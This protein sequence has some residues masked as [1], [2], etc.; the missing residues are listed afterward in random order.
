MGPAFDP[1]YNWLGIPAA[2]QPPNHYRLLGLAPLES[3]PTVIEHAADRVMIHLRTFAAGP[4]GVDSQRLLNE[5]ATARVCLLDAAKK[6]RYDADLQARLATAVEPLAANGGARL[7][8]A[9]ALPAEQTATPVS[10]LVDTPV[11]AFNRSAPNSFDAVSKSPRKPAAGRKP[12]EVSNPQAAAII[13]VVKIVMGGLGGLSMAILLVWVVWGVD[14]LGLFGKK[15]DPAVAKNTAQPK[16]K[17]DEQPELPVDPPSPTPRPVTPTPADPTDPAN[18]FQPVPD[19]TD[20]A[21]PP[22]T[23]SPATSPPSTKPKVKP[24]QKKKAPSN[25]APATPRR[26]TPRRATQR[27]RPG[28][29]SLRSSHPLQHQLQPPRP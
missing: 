19:P 11:I 5:V 17:P 12:N 14:A 8:R 6:A 29:S 28:P 2:E 9:A 25:P 23:S 24:K 16:P 22:S 26:A 15:D 4:H 3:N 1:Y 21:T 18:P 10:V 20:P 7:P 13:N 27:L